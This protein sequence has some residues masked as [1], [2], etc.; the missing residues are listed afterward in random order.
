MP[1]NTNSPVGA[2]CSPS[3]VSMARALQPFIF[4]GSMMNAVMPL[5]PLDLS[6]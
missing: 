2:Q 3:L 5:L 6:V 4:F 1:S